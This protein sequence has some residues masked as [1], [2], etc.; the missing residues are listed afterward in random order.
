MTLNVDHL[1]FA[2]PDLEQGIAAVEALLGIRADIGGKHT[3][4]GTHNALLSL[5]SGAYMEIIA[6]DPDQPNPS[7]PLPFGLATLT[8]PSLVTWAASATDIVQQV[9]RA[10]SQGYDPGAV[11]EMSR[12]RPDGVRLSWRLALRPEPAGDGLV[13]FLIDWEP[14]PHPSE[15]SPQG[16]VLESLRAEHPYPASVIVILEALEVDLPVTEGEKP[17]LIATVRCPR[18]AVEIA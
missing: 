3:G 2:A 8:E 16:C 13:P 6:P 17:R 12:E 11:I 1:V 7:R 4:L 10:R 18:G 14:G 15:T 5:G 9:E